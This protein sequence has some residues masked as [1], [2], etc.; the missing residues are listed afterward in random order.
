MGVG[1]YSPTVGAWYSQDQNWHDNHCDPDSDKPWI[2][3]DGYDSY[4]YHDVTEL[5]RAGYSEWDYVAD[6][7]WIHSGTDQEEYVYELYD[8]VY[9]DWR[10]KPIPGATE[11]IGSTQ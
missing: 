8:Q 7:K 5:D 9:W 2:D 11:K 10:T 6:G 4:G 3:R 1:K